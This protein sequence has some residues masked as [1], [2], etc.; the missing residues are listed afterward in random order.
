MQTHSGYDI[1][2]H[3]CPHSS[4][5]EKSII[6]I[7]AG[8]AGLATGCYGRMNGYRTH[9]LEHHSE[10]GGVAKAWK[11]KDYLIDGGIHY[12]MGH[13][14][15]AACHEIYRELGIFHNRTYPDL[16]NYCDFTDEISGQR[17]SFTADMDQLARDLK[18]LAPED[19][20]GIDDFIAGV[21]SFQ[22][23]DMF[24]TMAEPP[25]L[26]GPFGT[27]KQLWGLAPVAA[28]P[29]RAV[30]INRW[31]SSPPHQ[32]RG[33][34]PHPGDICSCPECPCGSSCSCCRCSPTARWVCWQAVATTSSTAWSSVTADSG[35]EIT[36]NATVKEIL[37]E[38]RPRRRRAARGRHR[39]ARRR[40][41]VR[42]RRHQHAVQSAGRTLRQPSIKDRY[43]NWKQ[44]RPI[45]TLSFRRA[46]R[47]SRRTAVELPAP[48]KADD[49]R[50]RD[51]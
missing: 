46:P 36:F 24:G 31:R 30:S 23:T 8:I 11:H 39:T 47:V 21:R 15:G 45:V 32:E 20:R 14:P 50:Q 40:R 3:G 38:N 48:E 49:H 13:R 10:P 2:P 33:V 29:R 7:G 16:T 51:D 43:Q 41:R 27:I 44:L 18:K 6:I 5:A 26:M 37:V 19:A 28:L 42:R 22:R 35:G 1:A 25:E 9:I 4:M 34:A 17:V 12:L